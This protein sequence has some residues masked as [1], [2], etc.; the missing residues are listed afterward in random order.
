MAK[1]VPISLIESIH[2]KLDKDENFVFSK[3]YG[4]THVWEVEPSTKEPTAN[5]LAQQ[6]RFATAA[7]QAAE[8]M[9]DPDKKAEWQSVAEASN[10]KWKTA[11]GAAFASYYSQAEG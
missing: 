9:K 8:D 6:M 10:G 7:S 1:I 2:G 4:N 5:Q 11:R 3:R